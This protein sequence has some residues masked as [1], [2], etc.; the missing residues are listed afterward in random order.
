MGYYIS[1]N[2]LGTILDKIVSTS[3]VTEWDAD[4][5]VRAEIKENFWSVLI[6]IPFKDLSFSETKWGIQIYRVIIEELK[7]QALKSTTSLA[8]PREVIDFEIDFNYVKKPRGYSLFFIP[9]VRIE[10]IPG[11]EIKKS[12][13]GK[14]GLTLRFKKGTS[15]LFDFTYKPDF[16]EVDVDILE[17]SITRLPV[18]YPEKRPFLLRFFQRL[19]PLLLL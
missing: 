19:F 14:G 9:S 8:N 5:K 6:L 7:I 18:N 10:R 3:G 12:Y 15:E 2:P 1:V 11:R 17:A 16:S 4:I 13:F